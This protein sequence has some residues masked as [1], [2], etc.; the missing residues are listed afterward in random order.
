[1]NY[2]NAPV[3][4]KQTVNSYANGTQRWLRLFVISAT[5]THLQTLKDMALCRMSCAN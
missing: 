4:S 2:T 5:T 1:M 3:S